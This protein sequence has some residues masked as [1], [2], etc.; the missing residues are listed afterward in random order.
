MF[1][2]DVC[3]QCGGELGFGP[4]PCGVYNPNSI[5]TKFPGP[6]KTKFHGSMRTMSQRKNAMKQ[7]KLAEGNK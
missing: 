5:I 6:S 3:D 1:D 4:C 2:D 7:A